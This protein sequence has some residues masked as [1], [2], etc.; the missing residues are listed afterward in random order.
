V[1]LTELELEAGPATFAEEGSEQDAL[2]EYL[3][4]NF[5]DEPF[6][7]EDVGPGQDGR[8][9][10]LNE[11]S[12]TVLSLPMVTSDDDV[13]NGQGGDETLMGLRGDD[14]LRGGAGSDRLFGGQ[15]ND[16]LQ[17]GR[18]SDR[19]LGERGNDILQGGRGS[20]RLFGG[21]GNDILQGGAGSDRLFG[22]KGND[23]LRGQDGDD[24]LVGGGGNDLLYGGSGKDTL[25]GGDGKDQFWIV[26]GAMPDAAS[27]VVDFQLGTDAIGI[28]NLSGVK[29]FDALTFTHTQ[30][31]AGTRL[32][33]MGQELAILE[34]IQPK[35]LNSSTFA[36]A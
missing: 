22:G 9:Q 27:T 33:A 32:L 11:R 17:G 29:S 28:A 34:G 31:E 23:I 7:V 24:N 21:K 25:T 13:I 3:A 15:G 1:D 35:S 8:I 19:L 36:F 30:D 18:G 6:D 16:T 14:I 2:A 12:D 10:N 4:A 26:N 5:T 20:D